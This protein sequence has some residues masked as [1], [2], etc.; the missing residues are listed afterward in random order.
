M[1]CNLYCLIIL[2]VAKP[3]VGGKFVFSGMSIAGD[4]SWE[5][6]NH[7]IAIRGVDN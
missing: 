3:K 4:G 7:N 2:Y 1:P 5:T 6:K